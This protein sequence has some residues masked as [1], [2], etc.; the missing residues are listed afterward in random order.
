MGERP[1][2]PK[3]FGPMTVTLV[4]LLG[5]AA[6][7]MPLISAD[8]RPYNFAAFGALG[9]FAAGRL[10]LGIAFLL[11]IGGKLISDSFNYAAFNFQPDYLSSW[12]YVLPFAVYPLCGWVL[13]NTA[14][15][16][17]IGGT[18]LISSMLFFL[19]S[20]FGA[21]LQPELKYP[22]TLAGLI[23]CYTMAL[24]FFKGTIISDFSISCGFFASHAY[25][26]KLYFP[27][28]AVKPVRVEADR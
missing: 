23:Q 16:F 17:A 27:A 22:Q 12:K 21:W 4:I 10:S 6:A 3:R 18:A 5:L 13:R 11:C 9:L 8:Y 19:V 20:N 24:P 28:E 7:A 2:E 14:N 15:P 26:A 25:L 1:D